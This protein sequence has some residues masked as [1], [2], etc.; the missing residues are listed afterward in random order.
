[1]KLSYELVLSLFTYTANLDA[2]FTTTAVV[3]IFWSF[4]YKLGY[5]IAKVT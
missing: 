4:L 3:N 1:M 5:S 2:T